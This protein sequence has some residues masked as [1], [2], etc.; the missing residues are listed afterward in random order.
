MPIQKQ[1]PV[2]DC[3]S[4]YYQRL[5]KQQIEIFGVCDYFKLKNQE[6]KEIPASV[7]EFGCDYFKSKQGELKIW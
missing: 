7:V 1:K 2:R 3:W 6:P 4:C 5:E